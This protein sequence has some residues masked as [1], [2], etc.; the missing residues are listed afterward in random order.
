MR[1][2]GWLVAVLVGAFAGLVFAGVSTYDFVQHLDRQVHSVHCSFIPGAGASAGA[3]G[4]QA[5]M[6]SSYS[7]VFRTSIWGGIPISLPAMAVFAFIL[8]YG[9]DL[10]LSR[11]K[12]DPRAT[13]FLALAC[14][15]PAL[16]SVT[17]LTISL[18]KLGTVCKLCVAIYIAS[19]LCLTGA[20]IVWRRAVRGSTES[21][22]SAKNGASLEAQV[23]SPPASNGFLGTMFGIGVGFV[24]VPLILY[25]MMA[26]DHGKFIG[27][28]GVLEKP[29]DTYGVMVPVHPSG[30]AQALEILDPLCPACKAFEARLES[31]G[32]LDDLNRKAILFPLDTTCNWMIT[33][34]THPGACAVSEAVLCAGDKAPEVIKWAFEVQ[35][36]VRE[37]TKADPTA[38]ERIVKQ[39]WP[40]LAAC[41][42]S[43]EAK[44]RL[45]KSLRWAV[46]NNIRVLTPQ[47]FIDN[48]KLCDEDV[49][50]GL[51]YALAK[52]LDGN[53]QSRVVHTA[54][55]VEGTSPST[56]PLPTYQS[57]QQAGETKLPATTPQPA[58]TPGETKPAETKPAETKPGETTPTEA[59]PAET[60]PADKPAETKP[61]EA[62]PAE[63]KPAETKPTE[64]KPAETKPAEGP[65]TSPGGTDKP[66]MPAEEK[67]GNGG[68]Q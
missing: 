41:V 1:P 21:V 65:V 67:P 7:S 25:M 20:I 57:G 6:M 50:I 17:M 2:P 45:N 3:T 56:A 49:D 4:C 29:D 60:K 35:D 26:P 19:A 54:K 32:M 47:L 44:S 62:K 13:A 15:L 33:E 51:D 40:E 14:A 30:K 66:A 46:S 34:N 9:V 68:G 39:R 63:T 37:Q 42:G 23:E 28:C 24:A 36:S 52:M 48:V 27:T 31:S 38:A 59:K 8:F 11:R 12:D 64:T 22:G 58:T 18:T 16:A 53:L 55:P 43:P 5:A 10:L 61:P